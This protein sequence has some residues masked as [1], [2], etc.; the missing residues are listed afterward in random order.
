MD[1]EARSPLFQ[2]CFVGHGKWFRRARPGYPR[3]WIDV[4]RHAGEPLFV[5]LQRPIGF[6]GRAPLLEVLLRV[7]GF[8]PQRQRGVKNPIARA[9]SMNPPKAQTAMFTGP[10][11][12]LFFYGTSTAIFGPM[13]ALSWPGRV[14]APVRGSEY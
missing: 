11:I 7:R 5:Q 4:C 1:G 14:I 3:L 13:I 10:I 8:S 9:N 2:G 12:V 6:G